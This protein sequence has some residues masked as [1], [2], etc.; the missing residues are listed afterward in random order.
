M[1]IIQLMYYCLAFYFSIAGFASGAENPWGGRYEPVGLT[2]GGSIYMANVSPYD[3]QLLTV[4]SDMSCSF[5]TTNTG[6]AWRM[7]HRD[8]IGS[9]CTSPAE[10]HPRDPN[11]IYWLHQSELRVTHDRGITWHSTGDSQP[12]NESGKRAAV[13]RIYVDP[14]HPET[15]FVGTD[16]S[17]FVSEDA[18]KTWRSCAG[19]VGSVI[20][21]AADRTTPI[22]ATRRYFVGTDQG[23]FRSDNNGRT[24]VSKTAGLPGGELTGFAG[25]S[26]GKTTILYAATPCTLKDGVLA[27][28]LYRSRDNGDTWQCIMNAGLN[29]ETKRTSEFANGDLP[30]YLH[31]AASDKLPTRVY[32]SGRG[33][34]YF[35]PNHCT[36]YRS[37]DAGETWRATFFSDPRFNKPGMMCNVVLDCQTVVSGNRDQDV[38]RNLEVSASNPDVVA[39][40]HGRWY[41]LTTDGGATWKSPHEGG[42]KTDADGHRVWR[43]N[44]WVVTSTWNYYIDPFDS[45]RRYLCYT[46]M[47]FARSFD[48]G[49]MWEWDQKIIPWKN[50]TYALAFD[51]EVKGRLWGAFSNVHDIPNENAIYGKVNINRTGGVGVSDDYG[52]TWRK[53]SLPVERATLSVV[54]DPHSPKEK[55]TL[56]ASV[57][58]SGVYRSD[59][60]GGTWQL[61]NTGLDESG[62]YR[63][64]KL[65]L[66]KDG[67]LFNL[68][69]GKRPKGST[70]GVGLYR[71]TDKGETWQKISTGQPWT[72]VKD[73][74]VDT[75]DSRIILVAASRE[76]GGLYR[77]LDGGKNWN[78]LVSKASE[79]FGGYFHPAH[80]G[81]IYLTCCEGGGKESGLY[82]SRDDGQTWEPFRDLP[83]GNIQRV[84]FDPADPDHII[85]TTFGSSAIRAPAVP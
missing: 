75:E 26:D 9:Q 10:F 55:R 8:E 12:W 23:V 48:G 85:L 60:G 64:L 72:W 7:L 24:F 13:K 77:T 81:W 25:P 39:M 56:Y 6:T 83:F 71:S 27:G 30:Q 38:T 33:T 40:S 78:L 73:F 42:G 76:K 61:K 51:P 11:T 4:S 44:G 34:S 59:D 36:I 80:K 84:A 2:A 22:G 52:N 58:G 5:L 31:L 28:G 14:D 1:K 63:C 20:R 19:T 69:T 46:D 3:S 68:T 47:G 43:N 45:Q 17:L 41:F 16:S 79:H 62:M 54:V 18:A 82:L 74:S 29:R 37:D 57:F 65:V 66:H 21:I 53:L 35:P 67:T 15:I 32:V 70:A 49:H 50:T